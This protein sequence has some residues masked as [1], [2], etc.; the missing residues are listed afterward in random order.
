MRPVIQ[1]RL[2]GD[3]E[4]P[5]NC[6]AACI[7]SVFEVG[8]D[9]VPDEL[10]ARARLISAGV[11]VGRDQ[12]WTRHWLDLSRWLADRFGIGMLEVNWDSLLVNSGGLV[13]D[14]DC[15]CLF[16]GVSPRGIPHCVVGRGIEII[17]DPHPSGGGLADGPESVIFFVSLDPARREVTA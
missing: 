16:N 1:T 13:E 14:D 3:P 6:F 12:T 11:E 17:H 8:L 2:G 9:E 5:G 15:V 7:A 4:R 10:D